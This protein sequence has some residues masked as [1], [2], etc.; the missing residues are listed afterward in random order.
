MCYRSTGYNSL[1]TPF[2][3]VLRYVT[4]PHPVVIFH[5]VSAVR[6]AFHLLFWFLLC[7]P[8]LAGRWF[9]WIPREQQPAGL[10]QPIEQHVR[11][12]HEQQPGRRKRVHCGSTKG[13]VWSRIPLSSFFIFFYFWRRRQ[14]LLSIYTSHMRWCIMYPWSGLLPEFLARLKAPQCVSAP[15]GS[16]VGCVWCLCCRG[17]PSL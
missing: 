17:C 7:F 4:E 3:R 15:W 14:Q 10:H 13:E 6:R 9:P 12:E 2:R 1:Q 5:R 11:R 16:F 8:L